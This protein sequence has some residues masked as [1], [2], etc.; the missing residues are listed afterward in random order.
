MEASLSPATQAELLV[1]CQQAIKGYVSRKSLSP[2]VSID[3]VNMC[4]VVILKC[5]QGDVSVRDDLYNDVLYFCSLALNKE[6][7]VPIFQL[8]TRPAWKPNTH[9]L[10]LMSTTLRTSSTQ[11][12]CY[13]SAIRNKAAAYFVAQKHSVRESDRDHIAYSFVDLCRDNPTAARD[14]CARVEAIRSEELELDSSDSRAK[15]EKELA[16]KI[17]RDILGHVVSSG[18]RKTRT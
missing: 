7:P 17:L 18:K 3:I 1:K 12:L 15:K 4:S 10:S 11:N 14:I 6:I 13:K 8:Y 16:K 9:R 2:Y 5:F